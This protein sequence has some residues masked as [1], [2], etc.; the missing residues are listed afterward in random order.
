[1]RLPIAT[2][3]ITEILTM[4]CLLAEAPKKSQPTP[5]ENTTKVEFA[6]KSGDEFKIKDISGA[7][8][9]AAVIEKNGAYYIRSRYHRGGRSEI[10]DYQVA[11]KI[12]TL[13]VRDR[14]ICI[15]SDDRSDEKMAGVV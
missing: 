14:A 1:M 6:I 7:E 3:G 8:G 5:K 2:I 9:K 13:L 10:R 12:S 11:K 15:F 4:V